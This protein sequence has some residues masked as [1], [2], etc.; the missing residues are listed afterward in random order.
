MRGVVVLDHAHQ[1]WHDDQLGVHRRKQVPQLR[2]AHD[3]GH[4]G[5]RLLLARALQVQ[6]ETAAVHVLPF[7]RVVL[8]FAA[9]RT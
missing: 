9:F 1:L 4:T 5:E 8:Y 6:E 2:A 3:D 7:W